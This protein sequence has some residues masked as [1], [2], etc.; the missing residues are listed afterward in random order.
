MYQ[1]SILKYQL[2]EVYAIGNVGYYKKT[3]NPTSQLII[4]LEAMP[5]KSFTHSL[6]HNVMHHSFTT[7]W[8]QTWEYSPAYTL[9]SNIYIT[10]HQLSM[11]R[12]Q[13]NNKVTQFV[14]DVHMLKQ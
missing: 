2:L 8:F 1:W 4:Y 13:G 12:S 5:C 7:T 9:S 10:L 11:L 6:T 14:S 3:E